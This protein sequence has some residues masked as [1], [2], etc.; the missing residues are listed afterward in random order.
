MPVL[1]HVRIQ[2]ERRVQTS[3]GKLH[4]SQRFLLKRWYRPPL[5]MPFDPLG[6][7]ASQQGFL[8]V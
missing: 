1:T 8:F 3:P 4:V 6:P 5:E 7:I 2:G